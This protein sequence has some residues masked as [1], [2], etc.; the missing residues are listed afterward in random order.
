MRHRLNEA[1]TE[2]G[3]DWM[4][5]KLNEAQT[6]W[7]TDWMRHRLNEA[8]TEWGTD[9]MRGTNVNAHRQGFANLSVLLTTLPPPVSPWKRCGNRLP[10]LEHLSLLQT[11]QLQC[12]SARCA[13][14]LSCVLCV[15][16]FLAD[17]PGGDH[18][19]AACREA[20][21]Q[22]EGHTQVRHEA[23]AWN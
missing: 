18:A 16:V 9:W 17:G 6:E 13:A 20:V 2:W 15:R 12:A 22:V 11:R 3:T 21:K 23:W 8:Q 1:Q 14:L 19:G 5:H 4:R 7:G 10:C